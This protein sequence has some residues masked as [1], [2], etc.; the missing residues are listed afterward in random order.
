MSS[1]STWLGLAMLAL[2]DI[3][4]SYDL[5]FLHYQ[6]GLLFL[7]HQVRSLAAQRLCHISLEN[8]GKEPRGPPPLRWPTRSDPPNG[9]L[10]WQSTLCHPY[11]EL[12]TA[13]AVVHTAM[14]A[15]VRCTPPCPRE[16]EMRRVVMMAKVRGRYCS[17]HKLRWATT[18]GSMKKSIGHHS[19]KHGLFRWCL[20]H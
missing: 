11:D 16:Q 5:H 1:S 6:R 17:L 9:Y 20:N 4:V 19:F 10:C 18:K 13:S 3:L 7:G 8:I 12:K 2:D 14:L 15:L